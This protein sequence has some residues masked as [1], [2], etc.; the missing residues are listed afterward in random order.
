MEPEPSVGPH[1]VLVRPE[2]AGRRVVVPVHP[3]R[4]LKPKTLAASDPDLEEGSY[5]VTVPALPGCITEG[6]TVVECV[7]NAEEAIRLYIDDLTAAGEP[8]PAEKVVPQA[9]T[10]TVA[11]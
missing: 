6:E 7:Q 11:A 5:T 10:V 4:I 9:I 2:R 3:G 1:V 8:V